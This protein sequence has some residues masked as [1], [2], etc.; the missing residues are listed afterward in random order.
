MNPRRSLLLELGHVSTYVHHANGRDASVCSGETGT[1]FCAEWSASLLFFR[2]VCP[3][4][5]VL[6]SSLLSLVYAFAMLCTHSAPAAQQLTTVGTP[7]VNRAFFY[8]I[9]PLFCLTLRS[10]VKCVVLRCAAKDSNDSE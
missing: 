1:L 6:K 9:A 10:A 2:L 3:F 8:A 5:T 7:L 4:W